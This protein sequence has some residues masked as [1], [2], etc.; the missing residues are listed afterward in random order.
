MGGREAAKPAV[1]QATAMHTPRNA[2]PQSGRPVG[3]RP[4]EARRFGADGD[5]CGRMNCAARIHRGDNRGYI[6]GKMTRAGH[7]LGHV[8]VQ[9]AEGQ[10]IGYDEARND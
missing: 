3:G 4:G 5:Q 7:K 10:S 1:W 2:W 6:S 8:L 9:F